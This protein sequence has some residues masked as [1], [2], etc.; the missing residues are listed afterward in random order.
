MFD[1][2]F[3]VT[4]F[5]VLIAWLAL[6]YRDAR[7][8]REHPVVSESGMVQS[9]WNDFLTRYNLIAQLRDR[10]SAIEQGQPQSDDAQKRTTTP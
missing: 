2:L 9:A 3:K 6:H 8:L 4:V 7:V 10:K 1:K 5:A